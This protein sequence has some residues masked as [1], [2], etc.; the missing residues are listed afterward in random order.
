MKILVNGEYHCSAKEHH[1]QSV[2]DAL[3]LDGVEVIGEY[4]TEKTVELECVFED[5]SNND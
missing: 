2:I 1:V 3:E 5:E 4:W